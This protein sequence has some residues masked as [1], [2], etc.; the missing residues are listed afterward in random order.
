MDTRFVMSYLR[1]KKHRR[2]HARFDAYADFTMVPRNRFV[3]NLLVAATVADI[4]G[5]IVE[6]GTWRGGMSAALAET[7]PGR[8]SVLFD[9]FAGLP[10][11]GAIDGERARRWQQEPGA[12]GNFGNCTA[13]E[14]EAREAMRR[15]GQRARFE[16]GWFDDTVPAYAAEGPRIAL[17]RLDADWYA[18]TMTC[19]TAL[20]PHVVTGGV[21][22][23]DDYGIWDGCTRAVHDHLA[24]VG[25]VE[26]I[27][28]TRTGV[29]Y[30]RRRPAETA[31]AER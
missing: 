22:L 27:Q 17:L 16:P 5:A 3:E 25:A 2:L 19:L 8:E 7:L 23:I 12:D 21:V 18:S 13:A 1:H 31:G 14:S 4:D 30:L 6:C 9:S 28:Q 15:S 29:A 20:W 26:P 10:P 24:R 11:A